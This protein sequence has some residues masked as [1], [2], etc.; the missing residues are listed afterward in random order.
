M[1][2]SKPSPA[3]VIAVVALVVAM[4]G[5]GYAALKLPKNSVGAKQIKANAVTSSK[6]K[7]GSLLAG[8]FKTGQ[9]PAGAQ[10]PVGPRGADGTNGRDGAN[11][12]NGTNGAKGDTGARGPSDAYSA[13]NQNVSALTGEA[14]ITVPAGDYAGSGVVNVT[15]GQTGSAP[16]DGAVD[17]RL[18]ADADPD[19]GALSRDTVPGHG[20]F[21]SGTPFFGGAVT[22][23]LD[24]TF[25]LPAGG[26]IVMA[27]SKSALSNNAPLLFQSASVQ[28]VRVESLHR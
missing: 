4:G 10:G 15:N 12:T 17:C 7:N 18:A 6:V 25:H 21:E 27:C 8:D 19:G 9:L 20:L 1:R 5:T 11:G 26:E 2:V 28:A 24:G 14:S 16:P 13:K 22:I 23:D 3:I